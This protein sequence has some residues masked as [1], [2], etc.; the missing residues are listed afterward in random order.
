MLSKQDRQD[1]LQM[2]RSA[3]VREEFRQMRAR[4]RAA[5]SQASLEAVVHWLSVMSRFGPPTRPRPPVPYARVL[6]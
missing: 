5:A 4:S 1:L 6:L 2:A 3:S